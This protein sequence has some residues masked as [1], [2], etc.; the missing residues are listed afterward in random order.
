MS[1]II[2]K[3]AWWNYVIQKYKSVQNNKPQAF[4]KHQDFW[5]CNI[6]SKNIMLCYRTFL[7]LRMPLNSSSYI[8]SNF[9]VNR[10]VI[11]ALCNSKP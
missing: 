4:H 7:M 6:I 5:D 9:R 8:Q 10:M 2:N 3:K 1:N 11:K